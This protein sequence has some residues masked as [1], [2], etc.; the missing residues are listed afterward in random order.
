MQPSDVRSCWL[1]PMVRWLSLEQS[2]TL[3]PSTLV[4]LALVLWAGPSG[5]A[6]PMDSGPIKRLLVLVSQTQSHILSD[7]NYNTHSTRLDTCF[8]IYMPYFI[9]IVPTAQQCGQLDAPQNGRVDLDGSTPGSTATYSCFSGFSL[10]GQTSRI[11]Q[12]NGVWSGSAPFCQGVTC[13]VLNAPQNGLLTL[14]GTQV[15]DTA[16]YECLPGFILQGPSVRECQANGQWSLQEPT[17][18]GMY[19]TCTLRLYRL[20]D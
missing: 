5:L 2:S 8:H 20:C 1:R 11:C 10:I 9:T 4:T 12:P 6:C 16:T 13:S 15:S 17:C 3:L 7:D 14:S 18:T 19:Y